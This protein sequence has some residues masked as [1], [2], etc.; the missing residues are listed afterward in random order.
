MTLLIGLA[1][2][3]RVDVVLVLATKGVVVS[4]LDAWFVELVGDEL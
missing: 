2:V 4:I 3:D 1:P